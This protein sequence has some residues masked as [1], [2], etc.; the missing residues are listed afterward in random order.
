MKKQENIKSILLSTEEEK[1]FK[2]LEQVKNEIDNYYAILSQSFVELKPGLIKNKTALLLSKISNDDF[3]PLIID[4]I[5][6]YLDGWDIGSLIYS[7]D[8]K[9]IREYVKDIIEILCNLNT[10]NDNFEAL[11]MII[12]VLKS[13]NGYISKKDINVSI[14]L[15]QKTLK[16]VNETNQEYSYL[17]RCLSWLQDKKAMNDFIASN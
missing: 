4:E 13:Y 5:K 6:K 16:L 8:E 11:E 2:L 15:I 9:N 10:K 1:S 3:V 7:L 12:L 17:N 14:R